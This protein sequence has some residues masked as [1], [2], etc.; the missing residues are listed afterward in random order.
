MNRVPPAL[1][2]GVRRYLAAPQARITAIHRQPFPGGLS[3]SRFQYWQ[4][5]L[6]RAGV[7]T[8]LM[9]VY[10]QGSVVA[11][12]FMQGAAQRESMAYATLPERVPLTLPVIVA[13]D[14]PAGDIWMLPFPPAKTTSHWRAEWNED[15]VRAVIADLARLHAAF[16]GKDDVAVEWSWLLRPTGEDAGRLLADGRAGLEAL[17]EAGN[18]DDILTPERVRALLS[19]AREP[20]VLLDVLN[21]GPMTLLHGDAGFQN[22]AITQDGQERIWYDWQLVGWG[23]SPLDWATFLHPWGY[24]E[25]RPPIPPEEMTAIYLAELQRRGVVVD[26]DTF[27]RQLD[28]AFLWRWLIQW[29]PLFTTHRQ[30]L[31]PEVRE[32]LGRAFQIYHWPALLRWQA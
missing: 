8:S 32:R 15:D 1:L 29:A 11:G 9:L 18:Y 26:T 5:S 28:A 23:L 16:W 22:V 4:L 2:W 17:T 20:A 6:R 10:K 31:R 7:A 30:R 14:V 12:A 13:V 25:A 27:F 19:L 3:G 21:V 24:P